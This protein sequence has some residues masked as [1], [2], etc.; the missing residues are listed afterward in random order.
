M[1]KANE[2]GATDAQ[3]AWN[4]NPNSWTWARWLTSRVG[5]D[6]G[7]IN[8]L[9]S[10]SELAKVLGVDEPLKDDD[11]Y[12]TQSASLA[13]AEYSAGYR[14]TIEGLMDAVGEAVLVAPSAMETITKLVKE[15]PAPTQ[16]LV[17]AFRRHRK[18][19]E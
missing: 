4:E 11:D 2:A 10:G 5:A 9:G 1:N 3:R 15:P 14:E 13:L 18:D 6:E 7:L 12:W 8:A 17:D 19:N 16:E